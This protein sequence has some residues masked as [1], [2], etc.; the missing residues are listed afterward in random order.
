[1][2]PDVFQPEIKQENYLNQV[3]DTTDI[4]PDNSL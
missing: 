4:F 2:Q 3:A 1:V